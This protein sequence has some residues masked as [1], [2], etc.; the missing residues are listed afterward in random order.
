MDS[1]TLLP[2]RHPQS[3]IFICDIADAAIK[4][5]LA[6]MEHPLFSLSTKPDLQIRRYEHGYNWFEITPSVKGLATIYDKDI[7][8]F[9]ISQIM[10]AKNNGQPYSK[11]VSFSAYDFLVFSNRMTNGQAYKGLLDALTRLRG[12]TLTTNIETAHDEQTEGFGLIDSFKARREKLDGRVLEWRIS[13]SDW[14][15]K[16]IESDE[17]L[18]LSRQYFR[19]RKP[20]ERRLYEV[21]RKH[22]GSQ[23]QWSINIELL[24]KKCGSTSAKR[25]FRAMLKKVITHQYLPDYEVALDDNRVTFTS[26]GTVEAMPEP[27][28]TIPH[29]KTTTYETFKRRFPGY[30]VY[31]V[32]A[33]WRKWAGDKEPPK[34]PDAAFLA[35]AKTYAEHAPRQISIL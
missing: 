17:V 29:L 4:D 30:D 18:T 24:Q 5:D 2:H 26:R 16:A 12:T 22:C 28:S 15:F 21:A 32:E 1:K 11:H 8:I 6:S 20:L 25:N 19:L 13:L 33:E 3:D 7:L 10:A 14:L 9:A 35:F 31:S 34:N 23:N 27:G